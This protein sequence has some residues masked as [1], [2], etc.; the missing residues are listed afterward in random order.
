[1]ES[2]ALRETTPFAN[3]CSD[4]QQVAPLCGSVKKFSNVKELNDYSTAIG[5]SFVQAR[6]SFHS[7]SRPLPVRVEKGRIRSV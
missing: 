2:V 6:I 7:S 3:G 4:I 5:D 1:M